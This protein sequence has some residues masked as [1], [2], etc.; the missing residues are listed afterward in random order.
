MSA[1]F[2]KV[3]TMTRGFDMPRAESVQVSPVFL[4]YVVIVFTQD[5]FYYE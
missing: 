1:R 4:G 5:R 3:I 2:Y